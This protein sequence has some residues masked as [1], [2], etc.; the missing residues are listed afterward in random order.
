MTSLE[1]C[2][3]IVRMT[4][5]LFKSLNSFFFF[6]LFSNWFVFHISSTA[7]S[8]S[9][10]NQVLLGLFRSGDIA[11][12]SGKPVQ[13]IQRNDTWLLPLPFPLLSCCDLGSSVARSKEIGCRTEFFYHL[14]FFCFLKI[15]ST[16][17]MAFSVGVLVY[18][19]ANQSS[20]GALLAV[21]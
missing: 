21:T 20:S 8:N 19:R 6:K 4:A 7:M 17:E 12:K 3:A 14:F 15:L 16:Q 5:P 13:F 18:L 11:H 9:Q 2:S 1:H 10:R